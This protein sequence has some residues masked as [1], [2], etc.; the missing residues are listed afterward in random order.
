MLIISGLTMLATKSFV[1]FANIYTWHL[2]PIIME[3]FQMIAWTGVSLTGLI[4]ALNYF[5]VKI[6]NPFKRKK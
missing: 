3:V 6:K 4:A 2:P 5:G 1:L